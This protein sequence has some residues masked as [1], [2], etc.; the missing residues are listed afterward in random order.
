MVAKRLDAIVFLDDGPQIRADQLEDRQ[1]LRGFWLTNGYNLLFNRESLLTR[2]VREPPL[3]SEMGHD[4]CGKLLH[5][6]QP[7]AVLHAAE[8]E[9]A[10]GVPHPFLL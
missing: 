7:L 4:L 10:A 9:V 5:G 6:A 3:R 2:A 1:T 8:G